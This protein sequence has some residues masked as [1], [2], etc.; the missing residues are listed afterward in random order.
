MSDKRN[1]RSLRERVKLPA[2]T[3]FSK[4]IVKYTG[5]FTASQISTTM[6]MV[7]LFPSSADVLL[8]ICMTCTA[9]CMTVFSWYFGKALGENKLKISQSMSTYHAA[10]SNMR[11]G[12]PTTVVESSEDSTEDTTVDN[13]G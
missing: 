9:G 8:S 13:N 6:I 2:N 1:R 5:I 7:C 3:E 12:T 10:V 11:T 4:L